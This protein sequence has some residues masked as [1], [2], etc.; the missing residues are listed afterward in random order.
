MLPSEIKA[1][2][3]PIADIYEHLTDQL[4]V[5]IAKLL[6]KNGDMTSTAEW[7]IK[8]LTQ[9]GQLN[10]QNIRII[11]DLTKVCPDLTVYAIENAAL[12]AAAELEP[13]FQ[14]ASIA[15]ITGKTIE[16]R[17]S[18][19][20][21]QALTHY[22]QQAKN[23]LNLVNTVMLYKAKDA[24]TGMVNKAVNI[25]NR[26]E[27]LAA[28]G[29]NTGSVVAGIQSRTG[30]LR[31]CI[32]EFSEKGLPGFVDKSGREWAPEAYI[33][34]DIRTT[35]NNVAHQ[36]QF[37]RMDDYGVDLIEVSSHSGARPR[38]EPYQGRLY[39][40]AN[41]SGFVEDLNGNRLYYAP[42]NTTSYG[43]PAGLLGINCGHQIYPFFP[44]LSRQTYSPTGNKEE[45]DK[46]YE[47]SQKQRYLERR[48]RSA[49]REAAMLDA[50]G[51]KEG[52]AE[53]SRLLKQRQQALKDF[54]AGTGRTLRLDRTQ[55]PE[56][57]KSVAGKATAAATQLQNNKT[58]IKYDASL[59][60]ASDLP[61]TLQIA[62][63]A[64]QKT[65]DVSFPKIQAVVPKGATLT[66]VVVLA[67][68]GTSTP[69]KDLKRL[70]TTYPDIGDASGWQKKTGT[71]ITSNYR[72]E[73]HWYENNGTV[74][75]AEVKTKGV[76]KP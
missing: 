55:V 68:N 49:K 41:K 50:L 72:Y 25:A 24:Y 48:V 30:A 11:A 44:G 47:Q 14:A 38:C 71:V 58:F 61:K 37:A 74:P 51:D 56:Y 5:N 76:K 17:A 1:L 7:Q 22:Q 69:I 62:D 75:I 19:G 60:A 32:R 23:T 6:A 70:Y 29:K 63:E 65:V 66:S 43:E 12:K 59:K 15:G 67:G 33:N 20:I 18:P 54:T 57:N 2:S 3:Q 53:A 28:L 31:Q 26:E 13:A 16:T 64:L 9:L 73:I 34:M 4:M 27:Y 10:Q 8:K 21:L 52:F 45:N 46:A 35:V 42:W 40:R 36:A 39:S